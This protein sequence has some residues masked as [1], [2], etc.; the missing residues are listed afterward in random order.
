MATFVTHRLATPE[1]TAAEMD[2]RGA[3][4]ER[5]ETDLRHW[6]E[7]CGKVHS[8]LAGQ[9]D[10]N[11]RLKE[12]LT[13][14]DAAIAEYVRYLH[15]GEMRGSY[16]GKPERNALI[17]AGYA[18]RAALAGEKDAPKDELSTLRT[19]LEVAEKSLASAGNAMRAARRWFH[20]ADEARQLDEALADT[21]TALSSIRGE[22]APKA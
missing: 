9:R 22:D 8:Q 7:E 13:V 12:T 17:K 3:V 1:E 4:I 15:G 2:R 18:T 11:A 21:A 16:D 19:K 6:R 5:L 20:D 10:K 14:A